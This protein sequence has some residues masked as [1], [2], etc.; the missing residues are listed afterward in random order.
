MKKKRLCSLLL[1]AVLLFNAGAG[2]MRGTFKPLAA[3]AADGRLY[4]QW[5][6]KW[7]EVTF[8]KYSKAG[9]SLYTSACGIF[10]FCNA[11]Y[12]LNSRKIDVVELAT[13]AVE[14]GALRPGAGGTYRDILY[15]HIEEKWGE[16]YGFTLGEQKLG[17]VRDEEFIEHLK[18]GGVAVL[19][20]PGHFIAVTGYN[21]LYK[22]YHVIE[23]AVSANRGLEPDSWVT[24]EKLT[25]GGTNGTWYVLISNITAPEYATVSLER[26]LCGV[27]EMMD[28]AIESNTRN[29]YTLHFYKK[30][31][32]TSLYDL[33]ATDHGYSTKQH[34]ICALTAAGEYEVDADGGNEFGTVKSPRFAFRVYDQKVSSA[35]FALLTEHAETGEPVRFRTAGSPAAGYTLKVTDSKDAA[36]YDHYV[37]DMLDGVTLKSSEAEWTP[38]YPG[39][40]TCSATLA[41][42]F[43]DVTPAAVKLTVN[44]DVKFTFDPNGGT[45]EDST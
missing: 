22:T 15:K 28:F 31:S 42:Y 27:E 5:D 8:T 24:A 11:M 37:A 39:E 12:G 36:V 20:V 30:G 10:S 3:S 32:E 45:L 2:L 38:E 25:N 43:G 26:T 40:Y 21:D 16:T 7:K 44:G 1:A 29:D 4:N 34:M 19:Y 18:S 35:S 23:S 9:N 6:E 17:T 13:W 41:N 14:I 33:P